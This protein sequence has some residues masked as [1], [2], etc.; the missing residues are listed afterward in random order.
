MAT[1]L[2]TRPQALSGF[3]TPGTGN[4][5]GILPVRTAA[6]VIAEDQ[7]L[8]RERAEAANSTP[9][10]LGLAAHIRKCWAE[11][12]KA[13]LEVE[14]I[15]K[16]AARAAEGRYSEAMEQELRA[17]GGSTV[18]MMLFASK[19]RAMKALVGEVV[20]G[21][22]VDKP[23]TLD[24]TPMPDLPEDIV[25]GILQ[26]TVQM[27]AEAEMSG[28]PMS[29]DDIAQM[30]RDAKDRA[31]SAISAEAKHRAGLEERK[32]H[33]LLV[34][35]GLHG[36]LDAFLDDLAVY[37]TA[38]IKGPVVRKRGVLRWEQGEEGQFEPV[39]DEDLVPQWERVD[40][41]RIYPSPGARSLQEGYLIEL[42]DLS[43][44]S[45]D[46][47]RGV[48]GYSEDA[49]N[50]LI[51]ENALGNVQQNWAVVTTD[52]PDLDRPGVE[53]PVQTVHA[54]QLWGSVTGQMLRDWGMD[55]EEVPDPTAKY[56]VEAWLVD[57]WV[58][59]AIINTDPLKRRPYYE[60]SYDPV[61]GKVWGNSLYATMRDCQAMCNSAARALDVNMGISSGPQ[62]WVNTDRM[63]AGED[64]S[65]MFPWKIWQFSSD[66][67][68][69]NGNPMDFF[70]P[71]SNSQELMAVYEKFSQLADEYTGIP[72]YMTGQSQGMGGASRTA[73][74]MSMMIGNAGKTI[75]SL[76]GL[77]DTHIFAPL[78]E[79]LHTYIMRFVDD[80]DIKGDVNIRARGAQALAVKEAAQIRRNEF[81]QATANPIDM[82]I[83]GVEGRAALLR[84]VAKTLDMDPDLVVPSVS[85]VRMRMAAQAMQQQ[86][87]AQAQM[88]AQ[89]AAQGDQTQLQNGAPVTQ[90]FDPVAAR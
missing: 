23:W 83:V 73:S 74:G 17:Q 87:L 78:L 59:R 51:E 71:G 60:C 9:A 12:R 31:Q 39:V 77:I 27:V 1:Q 75:K 61:P 56:E 38:F 11:A 16:E 82:E 86:Q 2:M 25:A 69:A 50:A 67:T 21:A 36:A 48:P 63:P 6:A 32:M 4:V 41:M 85:E 89:A 90:N 79:N 57:R 7:K 58:I 46:Q 5:G 53:E 66:P 88:A 37:P 30:L 28:M 68:G 84:E 33:D 34:E 80:P 40:P 43:L 26:G 49:I 76:V 44:D 8:A 42:H 20:L 15:M 54:L 62:V 13:R 22:D 19:K 3:G 81:L 65:Q 10:M 24:P 45:L 72:R 35:G 14:P 70:Q 29:Q 52:R 55:E 47:M 18:Y 64:I